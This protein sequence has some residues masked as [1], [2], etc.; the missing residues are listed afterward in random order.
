MTEQEFVE[1]LPEGCYF[2][3]CVLISQYNWPGALIQTPRGLTQCWGESFEYLLRCLKF[4]LR[5]NMDGNLGS[6][7]PED[8]PAFIRKVPSDTFS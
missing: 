4:R 2:H 5:F 1:A 7:R 8:L 6:N 3:H